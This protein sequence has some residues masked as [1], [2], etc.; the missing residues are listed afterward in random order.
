MVD[1]D[2]S[3]KACENMILEKFGLNRKVAIVTGSARGLGR[4]M[5]LALAEAGCKTFLVDI[6]P[7]TETER[8]MGEIGGSAR[9]ITCDL[10]EEASIGKITKGALD[11]YGKID[12]LVNNAG[13][14]KRYPAIELPTECWDDVM[15][16]NLRACFLLS[17]GVARE[18]MKRNTRGRII[19]IASMQSFQG[20]GINSGLYGR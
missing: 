15:N 20:G 13:I 18:M 10:Q 16:V 17:Q 3:I 2:I 4:A 7:P 6:I 11:A 5:A 8:D 9:S 1:S 19:N 14:T 12:V